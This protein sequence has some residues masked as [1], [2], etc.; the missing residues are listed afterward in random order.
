MDTRI[1][2]YF[3]IVAREENIT[4]AAQSLHITQPTLSR[5]L[6]QLESELGVKLFQRG[7]HNIYLTEE[8]MLFRRRAQEL[9]NLAERAKCE[10]L[11][12]GDQLTGEIAIGCNESQSMNELAAIISNFRKEHPLV[13]FLIRSGNN[14]EV[15]E[16]LEQG[17][18]DLGLFLEPAEVEKFTYVRMC[19]KDQWGILVHQDTE[20]A[21]R[22][23]VHSEELVGV[24][25]ITVLDETIHSELTNWSGK[26]ANMMV[27]IVHYNL[28]SNAVALV[29]KRDGV[30]VCSKPNCQYDE[31]KFVPFEPKLELGSLLAWQ[32]RQKF[33]KASAAF[34]AYLKQ[35][36]TPKEEMETME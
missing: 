26:N 22:K 18:I 2:N 35:Y 11:Q 16:R 29:R 27:P 36:N 23:V 19:K 9:V 3:L 8:G 25:L 31:L 33:S 13:Q 17:S 30:A 4:K 20:L 5:Q 6:M 7:N 1:L 14:N 15:R 12:A 28:L 32:G 10:L 34:I 21:A 24:P